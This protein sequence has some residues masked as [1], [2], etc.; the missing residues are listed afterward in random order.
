ECEGSALR[1]QVVGARRTAEELGRAFPGTVVRTSGRDEVLASV[2]AEPALVVATPGAEPVAD[3][4]YGAVLMLDTWALLGRA[5]LR[6]GEEALR[7]WFAAAALARSAT[8]GGRVILVADRGLAALQAL[9]RWDPAGAARRELA[10][11]TALGFPPTTRMAAAEG[12]PVEVAELRE[13]LVLPA[14]GDVLG[15]VAA[16]TGERVLFRV[17]RTHGAELAAAL[18]AAQAARGARKAPALR[19]ELDPR[20]LT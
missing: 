11:R 4:G 5:D 12:P 2:A 19:V 8:E 20:S 9:L 16:P 10:D 3:G 15:P 14:G 7:R 17:P 18:K 1:A 13:A 6:A